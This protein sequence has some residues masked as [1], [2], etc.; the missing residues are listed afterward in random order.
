[1]QELITKLE[2]AKRTLERVKREKEINRDFAK[3]CRK[4][5]KEEILSQLRDEFVRL[6]IIEEALENYIQTIESEIEFSLLDRV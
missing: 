2:I 4:E 6:E 1:M 5:G 3:D